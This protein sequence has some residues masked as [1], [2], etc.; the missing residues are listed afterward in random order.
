MRNHQLLTQVSLC[1]AFIVGIAIA[2]PADA[3]ECVSNGKIRAVSIYAEGDISPTTTDSQGNRYMLLAVEVTLPSGNRVTLTTKNY[4][5][6]S[7]NKGQALLQTALI[8][9]L[10]GAPVW[11]LSP[12]DCTQY[13]YNDRKYIDRLSSIWLEPAG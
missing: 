3:T 10:T 1:A 8:G 6:L 4:T 7:Q 9:Y 5:D 11:M 2:S 12:G 13:D